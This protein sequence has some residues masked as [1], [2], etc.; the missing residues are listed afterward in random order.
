MKVHGAKM[1]AMKNKNKKRE[2]NARKSIVVAVGFAAGRRRH[3]ACMPAAPKSLGPWFPAIDGRF[4]RFH[5]LV[6]REILIIW[7]KRKAAREH[8]QIPLEMMGI[9][10]R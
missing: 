9:E 4:A 7:R 6:M 10:A 1:H 8:A 2:H 5:E 3:R